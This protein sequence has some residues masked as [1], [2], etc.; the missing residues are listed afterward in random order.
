MSTKKTVGSAAMSVLLSA[1]L[2]VSPL[3]S[4]PAYAENEV[5]GGSVTDSIVEGDDSAVLG[6]ESTTTGQGAEN[7]T[8]VASDQSET[9]LPSDDA[10]TSSGVE[11]SKAGEAPQ[12]VGAASVNGKSYDT[13]QEAFDNADGQ[14]VVLSQNVTLTTP[15]VVTNNATL[16]LHGCTITGEGLSH[17][18][19]VKSGATLTIQ[20]SAGNG[21]IS[22]GT[23]A[24]LLVNGSAILESGTIDSEVRGVLVNNEGSSFSMT[25]G[26][27]TGTSEAVRGQRATITLSGG[28][29]QSDTDPLVLLASNATISGSASLKGAYGV[30]LFNLDASGKLN[31]TQG[32]TPSSVTMDG[33]SIECTAFAISGNNLQSATCSATIN[34]GTITA[35]DTAIY[36][37]MEGKLTVTGGS[38]TGGNAIEAKMGTISISGGTLTGTEAY[39]FGYSGGGSYSDGA[40]VK[41]V[42]QQY[43]A[44]EGQYMN[45][46]DLDVDITD[47]TLTSTNGNAVTVYRADKTNA[48]NGD[49]LSA[50]IDI[51]SEAT[52]KAA[53]GRDSIRISATDG[54]YKIIEGSVSTSNTTISSPELE[55]LVVKADTTTL[56]SANSSIN[57]N[58]LY[59]SVS[60]ALNDTRS[61]GTA[62]LLDDVAEDVVVPQDANVKIDL[63]GHTLNGTVTN[64]GTLQIT[65]DGTFEGQVTGNDATVDES[66]TEAVAKIG[67]TPYESVQEAINA[68]TEGQTVQ[69]VA[70][71]TESITVDKN[72][73]ITLDLNG[74]TLTNENNKH[75]I[76]NNGA[77][78]VIDSVGGG[79]VDNVSHGK[80]ALATSEGS[81]TTLNGGIFKRSQEAGT[82]D[83]ATGSSNAN[84]NSYYT[85]LN[86]GELTIND[87]TAVELLLADGTPA[88]HSS[89]IDNGWFSGSPNEEGYNAKLTIN[90]GTI[91]GGKYVKNDSYGVLEVNGGKLINGA[92]TSIL[93]WNEATINGGTFDPCDQ[94]SG[95]IYNLKDRGGIES[96]TIDIK[97]GTFITTGS[98]APFFTDNSGNSSD[99]IEVSGGT[100]QGNAPDESYIVS[101]SGLN[102]N[103]DGSFGVHAHSLQVVDAQ[104]PSCTEEGNAKYWQCAICGDCFKDENGTQPTTPEEMSIPATGHQL[105]HVEASDPTGTQDGNIEY[106][107]CPV[108]HKYFSDAA[109]KTE[110]DPSSV[111]VPAVKHTVTLVY[112]H[113]LPNG[114]VEVPDGGVISG[115]TDPSYAGWTFVGW[116]T[117]RAEDG[118]VS[119]EYQ[120]GQPITE[121]ITLYAGWV[122]ND[123]EDKIPVSPEGAD[124]QKTE[125]KKDSATLPQ[126]SDSTN[127]V[128]P[129]ALAAV[130]VALAA[131][132]AISRRREA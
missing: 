19:G 52:L 83:Y 122:Q 13:L 93:N 82:L 88:G 35:T 48:A 128:A 117:N 106:W 45:S 36:W 121:D 59:S 63:G 85:I 6:E 1:S 112:G 65:G 71:V 47:G 64:N 119:G 108:C 32:A 69:L 74:N 105:V 132:A 104:D 38:I 12:S 84:G 23:T 80:A 95:I 54:N 72:D 68:A 46:P 124:E 118:T 39:S 79:V 50:T 86:Q 7:P 29:V 9:A 67:D 123:T 44:S 3:L 107:T 89:I 126:T 131:G 101:G 26:S 43:G 127:N 2:A 33:G 14:T 18:V 90:G 98:Q 102:Q 10:G 60:S 40:A 37:P 27:V 78:T 103:Q 100:Y 24:A 73:S 41:L 55:N 8:N 22:G 56:T 62:T 130:G 53:E 28:L 49:N 4:V 17:I 99:D 110:I 21:S 91:N 125:N 66:V 15:I 77:L 87:G 92:N 51:A 11:D 97:G 70:N 94:A 116:F 61:E 20:D 114:T 16:D 115:L 58:T 113:G 75:T 81:T 111:V 109:G 5:G 30:S 25:G 120:F 129:G 31:N 96:G 57:S 76:T 34:G 42:T